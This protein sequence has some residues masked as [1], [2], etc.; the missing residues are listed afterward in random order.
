MLPLCANAQPLQLLGIPYDEC[1]E[2]VKTC[3]Q[4]KRSP[5]AVDSQIAT[6]KKQPSLEH[7]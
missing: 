5:P 4:R 1:R 3:R 2:G 7:A 6:V